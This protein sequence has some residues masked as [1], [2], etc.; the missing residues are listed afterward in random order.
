M[1]PSSKDRVEHI[2]DAINQV[3]NY[4]LDSDEFYSY[5]TPC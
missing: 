3:E 4:T 1:I 5:Q 2:I